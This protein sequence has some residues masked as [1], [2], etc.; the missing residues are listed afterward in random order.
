M[1]FVPQFNLLNCVLF[2]VI[3]NCCWSKC[4]IF[5]NCQIRN[6]TICKP[7]TFRNYVNYDRKSTKF[8]CDSHLEFLSFAEGLWSGMINYNHLISKKKMKIQVFCWQFSAVEFGTDWLNCVNSRTVKSTNRW[9]CSNSSTF[10]NLCWTDN[11]SAVSGSTEQFKMLKN[12]KKIDFKR[13][14]C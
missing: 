5:N 9:R 3:Q 13:I 2:D 8:G 7:V 4:G 6:E 10:S 11:F 12:S 1:L 14:I